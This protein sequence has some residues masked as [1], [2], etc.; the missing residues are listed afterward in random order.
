[1]KNNIDT[2]L[3]RLT[4][5]V[6]KE[7]SLESP[8]LTFTDSIMSQVETLASR[9]VTVYKPLISKSVGT[10]IT[11]GIIALISYLFFMNSSIQTEALFTLN[12]E[13]LFNN[14]FTTVLSNIKLSETLMYVVISLG[15]MLFI[16]IPLLKNYFDKRLAV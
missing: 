2:H 7:T 12:F 11:I 14:R 8:S 9:D 5:K 1:M 3:D 4:K 16:Q 15:I 6:M 13:V 10:L